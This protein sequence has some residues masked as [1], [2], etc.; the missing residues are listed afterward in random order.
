[1]ARMART[2]AEKRNRF[3]LQHAPDDSVRSAFWCVVRAG[4]GGGIPNDSFSRDTYPGHELFLCLRGSGR[5]RTR[6]HSWEVKA[7]DALWVNCYHPHT[8]TASANEPW[9]Y[10]WLRCEG[11]QLDAVWKLI[12]TAGGPVAPG[13][14]TKEKR[15]VFERIF[16]LLREKP[17]NLDA[18][19]HAEL[20]RW[21]ALFLHALHTANRPPEE[22]GDLPERLRPALERMRLYHHLP[23]RVAEMAE[24]AGLSPSHFT[25]EF[26]AALGATPVQWLRKIRVEQAKRRLRESADTLKEIATQVGYADQFYFSRDFKQMTG[27]A[28]SAYRENAAS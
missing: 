14:D 21:V 7:G 3:V 23:L 15:G 28:P 27:Q 12:M 20:A 1:M 17:A 6:G 24:L 13:C 5:A 16:A 19:I 10:Y 2:Y 26:R 22:G 25:R 11:P 18:L 9:E 4:H 8:Y